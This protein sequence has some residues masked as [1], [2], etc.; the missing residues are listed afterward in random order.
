ML[1]IARALVTNPRLL[2]LDEPM[3]GL[4]PVI[5]R[6]LGV[7]LGELREQAGM[8]MLLVEQHARLALSLS[9]EVLVLDRGRIVHHGPSA[10]LASD[11]EAQQRL[12]G[13]SRGQGPPG[14]GGSPGLARPARP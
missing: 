9:D 5:V 11:P 12:L 3:E 14:S 13:I 2:L 10:Q 1:A 4:A 7:V 8:A 6:E